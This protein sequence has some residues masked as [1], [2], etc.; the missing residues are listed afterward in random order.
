MLPPCC[1]QG[2]SSLLSRFEV[3]IDYASPVCCRS[4]PY[5][6]ALEHA[7]LMRALCMRFGDALCGV[8]VCG[9]WAPAA[10]CIP[11]ARMNSTSLLALRRCREFG[12][13]GEHTEGLCATVKPAP[14]VSP[15]VWLASPVLSPAVVCSFDARM[16]LCLLAFRRGRWLSCG[17]AG[18]VGERRASVAHSHCSHLSCA[19]P[20]QALAL[21]CPVQVLGTSFGI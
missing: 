4:F 10:A 16:L 20:A 11:F 19:L 13:L 2:S 9:G 3:D 15:A 12:R 7:V 5:V 21:P 14:A 8:A 6:S 17:R 1:V 18:G